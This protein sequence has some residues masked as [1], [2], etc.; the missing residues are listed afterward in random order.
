MPN[1]TPGIRLAG[2]ALC[3]LAG[4]FGP[5]WP[6]ATSSICLAV[7][8]TIP[9]LIR[10]RPPA[11]AFRPLSAS[12]AFAPPPPGAP[13]PRGTPLVNRAPLHPNTRPDAKSKLASVEPVN[14]WGRRPSA[15]LPNA[16]FLPQGLR[17]D[18][19]CYR[20]AGGRSVVTLVGK[21]GSAER[22]VGSTWSDVVWTAIAVLVF[23]WLLQSVFGPTPEQREK[24]RAAERAL[25]IRVCVDADM[26]HA[27]TSREQAYVWCAN[28]V[29]SQLR[30]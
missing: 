28:H 5:R 9:N 1:A 23:L 12:P 2:A 19:M 15:H 30:R 7:V 3:S 8:A 10:P 22:K 17:C 24:A 29:P 21:G 11:P 20:L 26:W 14:F 27:G 6:F 13:P 25:F 4:L 18:T 16:E